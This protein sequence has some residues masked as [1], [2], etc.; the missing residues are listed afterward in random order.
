[1][2]VSAVLPRA[3]FETPS[4]KASIAVDGAPAADFE[5]D[6]QAAADALRGALGVEI[7]LRVERG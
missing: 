7:D 5:L 3:L 4:L 6:V 2:A 1:M